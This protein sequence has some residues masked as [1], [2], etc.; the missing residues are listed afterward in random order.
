MGHDVADVV[1]MRR[2]V[3]Y[4]D[5]HDAADK[6]DVGCEGPERP[7]DGGDAQ[8]RMVETLAEHLHL[9]DAVERAVAQAPRGCRLLVVASACCG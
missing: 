6:L 3:L 8:L 5:A 7:E 9:D 2:I 1:G 4:D